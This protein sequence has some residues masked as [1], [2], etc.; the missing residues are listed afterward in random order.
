M[1]ILPWHDKMVEDGSYTEEEMLW[2]SI[3]KYS[4]IVLC[5]ATLAWLLYNAWTIL[6]KQGKY[7]VLPLTNFY[8]LALLLILFRIVYQIFSFPAAL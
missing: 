3:T 2:I 4:M 1:A 8:A 6:I 7:D 5:L